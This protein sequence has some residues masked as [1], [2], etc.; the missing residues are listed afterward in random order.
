MTAPSKSPVVAL[1]TEG[2][3]RSDDLP[4]SVALPTKIPMVWAAVKNKFFAQILVPDGGSAD[5]VLYAGRDPAS[6]KKADVRSVWA[7]MTYPERVLEPGASFSRKMNYYVGPKKYSLL[8]KR[9]AKQADIM[10]FGTWFG[11]ICKILLP[12]LNVI[13]T[14]TRNYGVAIIVLTALVRLILWPLTYKS[15]QSMKKM[16]EINPQVAQIREKYKDNPKRMNQ[17]VMALYKKNKVNPMAGCLP[18][19]LQIPVFFGL[20]TVLR[21]AIEL[22][23]ATF[24]WI[25]DLS[26]P[27]GLFAG[28]IPIIGSL[29][30]LPLLMTG[31]TL[32]QQKLTPTTGDPS[33]QKMMMIMPVVMLFIFY[34]MASALV[35]YWTTSTCLAIVEL[36]VQKRRAAMKAAAVAV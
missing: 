1:F 20:F 12:T 3:S 33:Q 10:E 7:G 15:T 27:E 36:Y 28:M 8:Q 31:A 17:E 21:S 18:I 23:F 30:I 13:Q 2:K 29:N 4:L 25:G 5:C 9:S 34:S 35:L 11:W 32:L 6:P 19:L 16:Q 22:R 26:E 14:V 24:L